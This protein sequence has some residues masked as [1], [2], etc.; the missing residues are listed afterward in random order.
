MARIIKTLS[1]TED[2]Q[3]MLK[4]VAHQTGLKE[5]EVVRQLIKKASID[6]KTREIITKEYFWETIQRTG[7]APTSYNVQCVN[8]K[9]DQH[10]SQ[11]DGVSLNTLQEYNMTMDEFQHACKTL[12]KEML[13]D[14]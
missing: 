13:R 1:F 14:K 6:K 9:S 2:E 8:E 7:R 10:H 3:E 5:S 11:P 4:Q 12:K